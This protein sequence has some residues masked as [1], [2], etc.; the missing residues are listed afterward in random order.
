VF[1]IVTSLLGWWRWQHGG[2]GAQLAILQSSLR[3]I[4]MRSGAAIVIALAY[5]ALLHHFTNAYAPF[6]DS[7]IL[8]FSVLA[9]LLLVQR[10]IENWY[11]WFIVNTIAVPL[12]LSRG[13]YLTALFY[14][15]YWCNV[16]YGW[17]QWRQQLKA[18]SLEYAAA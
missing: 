7:L 4:G 11:C 14:A 17:Y 15:I 3:F 5:G 1:F 2:Q 8:T 6:V 10:R 9:Q 12:Y 16:L 18:E 13:L